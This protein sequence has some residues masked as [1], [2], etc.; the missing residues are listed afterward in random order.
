MTTTSPDRTSASPAP[1]AGDG[2][3]FRPTVIAVASSAL[4]LPFSVTGAAVALPV[5]AADL[6]SSVGS[7]QWMLNAFNIGFAALPLAAGSLADR[8]GRR[9]ML[10]AGIALVGA[11][12]LLV[13][14]APSMVLVDAARP[15]QGCGAA[16]VLASGAAVSASSTSPDGRSAR[17][18]SRRT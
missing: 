18:C 7:A 16:A 8:Y 10:L 15:V 5:M 6:G 14:L 12:S 2:Q 1:P 3:R 4:M 17:P 9:R 11:M 13:A